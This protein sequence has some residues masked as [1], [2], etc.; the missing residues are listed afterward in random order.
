[1][2]R[3]TTEQIVERGKRLLEAFEVVKF[4][5]HHIDNCKECKARWNE[6]R[7]HA[8]LKPID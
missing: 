3:E 4:L 5:A 8:G 7:E 1:M 2:K 6:I